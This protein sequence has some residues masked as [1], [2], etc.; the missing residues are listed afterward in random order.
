MK[1]IYHSTVQWSLIVAF[2]GLNAV[3]L[4][5]IIKNSAWFLIILVLGLPPLLVVEAIWNWIERKN[6]KHEND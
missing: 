4:F 2:I 5:Y 3:L 6:R 1:W